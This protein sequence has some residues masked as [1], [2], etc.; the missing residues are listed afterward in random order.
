LPASR[1]TEVLRGRTGHGGQHQN[2]SQGTRAE[3]LKM[4]P[5]LR[6]RI[7]SALHSAASMR[8]ENLGTN[9]KRLGVCRA[10]HLSAQSFACPPKVPCRQVGSSGGSNVPIHQS[11]TARTNLK[12]KNSS[13]PLELAVWQRSGR[14]DV[15]LSLPPGAEP[16]LGGDAARNNPLTPFRCADETTRKTPEQD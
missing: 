6:Q 9:E 2:Y 14:G 12:P 16:I 8:R 15:S 3:C 11:I 10:D 13:P 7:S 4:T 5:F 1:G